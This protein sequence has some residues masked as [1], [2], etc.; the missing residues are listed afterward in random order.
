MAALPEQTED[1]AWEDAFTSREMNSY[2]NAI[3][4]NKE[5]KELFK[6]MGLTPEK[7]AQT[8][9]KDS[10]KELLKHAR[11]LCS[12]N[13]QKLMKFEKFCKGLGGILC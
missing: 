8:L 2:K 1:T 11:I 9:N 13:D 3:K 12:P 6:E 5:V 7:D 4:G 10:L